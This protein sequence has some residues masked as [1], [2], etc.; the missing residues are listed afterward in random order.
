MRL[1]TVIVASITVILLSAAGLVADTNPLFP[2]E[3]GGKWGFIDRTGKVVIAPQFSRVWEF[4]ED[5][6]V[7]EKG[8]GQEKAFGYVDKTGKS[9]VEPTF[10]G[11]WGFSEGL[12]AVRVG[13]GTG[14]R[15]GF[16]DKTG[17]FVIQPRFDSLGGGFVEG[18]A[19]V[20]IGQARAHI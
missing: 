14:E 4:S 12:A 19:L 2:V 1:K 3:V 15:W 20:R 18:L 7:V 11:T 9:A 17:K 10:A 13:N 8:Y 6:A 16:I 5:M